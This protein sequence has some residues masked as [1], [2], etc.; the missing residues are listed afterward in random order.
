MRRQSRLDIPVQPSRL[1]LSPANRKTER[2]E[3]INVS[4]MT[5][6][7]N[8]NKDEINC[9]HVML[10]LGI[11]RDLMRITALI[12]RSGSGNTNWWQ[13][14]TQKVLLRAKSW[15]SLLSKSAG[16]H[17]FSSSFARL[18]RD[19]QIF[20]LYIFPYIFSCRWRISKKLLAHWNSLTIVSLFVE[21]Y[22]LTSWTRS[23]QLCYNDIITQYRTVDSI[24][25]EFWHILD[26]HV[27]RLS[28]S[29]PH[30]VEEPAK[31]N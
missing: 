9:V 15:A 25:N 19:F 10:G 7:K 21:I 16:F 22:Q 28:R 2:E 20:C 18:R 5:R 23:Y 30:S 4:I 13:E 14:R 31:E 1:H 24:L 29:L 11:I 27:C 12:Y 8:K 17:I 26:C 6:H 3:R